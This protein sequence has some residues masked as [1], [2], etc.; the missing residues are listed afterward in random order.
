[1]FWEMLAAALLSLVIFSLVIAL[2]LPPIKQ[3]LWKR[4]SDQAW[5]KVTNT[6]YMTS[7][8][9]MWST[10]QRANPQIFL[11]N[12]LRASQ[13]HAIERPIGTPLVFSHWEQLVFNPAQ[14]S[15]IPAR[16]RQEIALKT[17]IGQHTERPLTTDI[18]ILIAG[19]SYGSALSMKA[20]IA[21]ALGANMA[22]TA[23]NTGESFLPEERDA[24]KRLIVQYH[25]GTWPLSVQN[26]PRFL[27]SADAIEVQ[28]GRGLWS[29]ITSIRRCGNTLA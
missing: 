23:T 8:T 6:R 22:G 5:N 17:T 14:L 3:A 27:E 28:I 2:L 21:L 26:H 9:S 25:R 7:L 10:L 19:M 15:R 24:A 18:P 13:D 20:K 16:R 11:E 12:S 29:R 1:M 4:L